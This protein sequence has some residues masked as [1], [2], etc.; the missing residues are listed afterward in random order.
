MADQAAKLR[1]GVG[2]APDYIA[3]RVQRMRCRA[4]EVAHVVASVQL[5]RLQ[6]RL[7][8][9]TGGAVKARKRR[10]PG[11]LRRMRKPCAKR[12]CLR[13]AEVQ[14]PR[15]RDLDAR[16]QGQHVSGSGGQAA[17]GSGGVAWLS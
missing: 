17:G 12:T 16:K 6:Q 15:L 14:Q 13:R 7:R 8:P 11:G 9:E 1:A 3:K 5:Q 4:T 10:A 2:L